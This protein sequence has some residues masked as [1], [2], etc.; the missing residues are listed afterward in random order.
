M[1]LE[2][3]L[4]HILIAHTLMLCFPQLSG[5]PFPDKELLK[6]TVKSSYYSPG[7]LK[8]QKVRSREE[9]FSKK[10]GWRSY[11]GIELY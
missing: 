8:N 11:I 6:R 1:Y 2:G 7:V 9:L 4:L 3:I 10:S 5:A